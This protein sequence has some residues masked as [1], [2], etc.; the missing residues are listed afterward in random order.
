MCLL[1]AVETV[2]V[3]HRIE[4]SAMLLEPLPLCYYCHVVRRLFI[5]CF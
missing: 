4:L 3:F 1:I 2:H 5:F